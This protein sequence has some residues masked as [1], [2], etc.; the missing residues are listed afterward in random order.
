MS[1]RWHLL[2]VCRLSMK[3]LCTLTA[4]LGSCLGLRTGME[5]FSFRG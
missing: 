1:G 2:G 4:T 5:H 3:D